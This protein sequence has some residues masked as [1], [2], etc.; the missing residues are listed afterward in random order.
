M[1]TSAELNDFIFFDIE[2]VSEYKTLDDL[3]NNEPKKDMKK[4]MI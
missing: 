3:T 4:I 1:F 2:T